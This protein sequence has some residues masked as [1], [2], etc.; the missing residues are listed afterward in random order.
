MA[1]QTTVSKLLAATLVASAA[2]YAQAGVII[3]TTP[4]NNQASID[5]GAGQTFTTGLLGGETNLVSIEVQ[6][7]TSAD[8][9]DVLTYSLAIYVDADQNFATWGIGTKLG[10]SQVDSVLANGS[11]TSFDFSGVTLADNTV[12]AIRFEDGSG[13]AVPLQTRFR[14]TNQT[15]VAL[16]DGALFSGVNQ[17]FAGAFD[18]AMRI[19]TNVPEP[20]SIALLAIGGLLIAKRRR[21]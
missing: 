1:T 18:V 16:A 11:L 15:G 20:G 19:T 7:P 17:P 5:N 2:S 12:Y 14:L 3:D 21:G 9:N 6:G 8:S 10:E 13:N 4:G